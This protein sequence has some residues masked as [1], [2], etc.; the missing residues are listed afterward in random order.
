M[1]PLADRGNRFSVPGPAHHVGYPGHLLFESAVGRGASGAGGGLC[2]VLDLGSLAVT[3]AA[4]VRGL[5][6]AVSRRGRL[7]DIHRSLE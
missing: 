7:V 2:S 4:Y 5:H 6:R 3:P 1:Y